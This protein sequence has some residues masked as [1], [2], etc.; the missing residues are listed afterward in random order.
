VE[1]SAVPFTDQ[2]DTRRK[3]NVNYSQAAPPSRSSS[4]APAAG[5][6]APQR[7]AKRPG[8]L[9]TLI[10][11]SLLSAL[12]AIV[13]AVIVFSGGTGL[14]DSNV[15]DVIK[16]HPDV[17]GVPP[18]MS[19]AEATK[20]LAGPLWQQLVDDRAGTLSARAGFAVFTAVC[21]LIFV[22]FARKA[23]TW[24]RVMLTLSSFVA[25]VPCCL[26]IS[27]YEPTSVTALSWMALISGVVA[28][29]LCWSPGV[30]RYAKAR[31]AA[32]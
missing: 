29:V 24:S 15:K 4:P 1:R 6:R 5:E 21:M 11:A 32:R 9:T 27:D 31:S 23:S 2:L 13:G 10:G 7:S 26:I 17:V 22:F 19:P 18:G 25:I 12:C 30:S 14:A 28:V 8:A 16:N 20:A 3:N